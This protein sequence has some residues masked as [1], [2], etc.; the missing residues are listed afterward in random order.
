MKTTKTPNAPTSPPP[1]RLL[2]NLVAYLR[3]LTP[4][5]F[6]LDVADRQLRRLNAEVQAATIEARTVDGG[7]SALAQLMRGMMQDTRSPGVIDDGEYRTI[8]RYLG[9][10]R[11]VA[12]KH[13]R[14]LEVMSS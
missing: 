9:G 3:R 6:E 4:A 11:R 7:C 8:A 13:T 5:A 12:R 1:L 10:V 2:R 14:R